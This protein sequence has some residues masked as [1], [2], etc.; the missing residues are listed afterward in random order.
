MARSR[1]AAIAML[2]P[3]ALPMVV[4]P[5]LETARNGG[6]F[7]APAPEA[8]AGPSNP[9][10]V[11]IKVYDISTPEA[12]AL[13]GP[14]RPNRARHISPSLP[15]S[16][17]PESRYSPV[18]ADC[19]S[20]SS[21]AVSAVASGPTMARS[22]GLSMRSSRAPREARR[23]AHITSD[24]RNPP[25]P[26]STRCSRGWGR[27]I[28]RPRHPSLC[29]AH[30][31]STP[32]DHRPRP[33]SGVRFLLPQLQPLLLRHGRAVD[34]RARARRIRRI[35]RS[36]APWA[37]CRAPLGAQ[38]VRAALLTRGPSPRSVYSPSPS[39]CSSIWADCSSR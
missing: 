17:A 39:L 32:I 2:M 7:A 10:D 36:S 1:L 27:P 37:A 30:A 34:Q 28:T 9:R 29:R 5:K 14:R 15:H 35:H 8:P 26:R 38:P 22:S 11:L 18:S 24:R 16:S 12:R 4:R 31:C 6:S 25:T 33:L 23:Y 13:P 3:A 20:R 21:R 19:G